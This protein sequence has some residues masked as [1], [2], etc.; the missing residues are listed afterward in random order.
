MNFKQLRIITTSL[1]LFQNFLFP[2]TAFA[3]EASSDTEVVE[4]TTTQ[5]EAPVNQEETTPAQVNEVA[6]TKETTEAVATPEQPQTEQPT[7]VSEETP[8]TAEEVPVVQG[9]PAL[10]AQ[11]TNEA[12]SEMPADTSQTQSAPIID[13]PPLLRQARAA[14]FNLP[15]LD[16]LEPTLRAYG[17]SS[18]I[19][20]VLQKAINNQQVT[21]G[22]AV[23]SYQTLSIPFS[24]YSSVTQDEDRGW[25]SQIASNTTQP[26]Y[27][28]QK[29]FYGNAPSYPNTFELTDLV[30]SGVPSY[31]DVTA[32]ISIPST[33]NT[34]VLNVTIT[35][36]QTTTEAE[37]S[38]SISGNLKLGT[39]AIAVGASS[40]FPKDIKILEYT[41][42]TLGTIK[43]KNEAPTHAIKSDVTVEAQRDKVLPTA[44][45]KSWFSTLPSNAD[46]YTYQ[47][48][49][50]P[51]TWEPGTSGKA[52]VTVSSGGTSMDYST[53]YKVEDTLPPTGTAQQGNFEA[54]RSRDF[55]QEE[56]RTLV[57]DL[58]DNWT[59]SKN[60][61]FK[62]DNKLSD[63]PPND[64]L[65]YIALSVMDEAGNTLKLSPRAY[66]KDT[67]PPEGKLKDSLV[68]DLGS[69]EPNL[70]ELL[71]GDPSDNWTLPEDIKL[72]ITFENGKKFSELPVGEHAFT[73]TLTD[74]SNNSTELKG[75]LTIRSSFAIQSDVIV[76]AQRDKDLSRDILKSWFTTLPEDADD[77]DY[78]VTSGPEL[79][80]PKDTGEATVTVKNK[81]TNSSQQFTTNY[82]V[83]DTLAP[84]GKLKDSLEF[85]EGS[86]EPDLHELLDG[87]PTDNWTLPEDIKLAI[88]FENGK[89]FSELPVGEHNFTLTLTDESNNSTELK[90]KLTIRSS[91]AIQSDVI[92]EAQRD[93]ELSLGILKSWFTTLPEKTDDYDYQVV[94]GPETWA[95]KDTGKVTV[96]VRNKNTNNTQQFTTNYTV[97]DTL[98]PNGKLKDALEFEEGSAEPD[99][100]KLLD[101]DPTDNWSFPDD[102]KLA[103]T[104]ENGKKF[105]EL[106][107]GEHAFTLTLT[108]ES[109]NS[110]ELKGS[111]HIFSKNKYIDVVIP[112]KM[113]FAQDKSSDGIVSPIYK[114]QNNSERAL[115]VSVD[116][117][118]SIEQT[119]RL[120]ELTLG[121][122]NTQQNQEILLVSN[123]QNLSNSVELGTLSPEKS[124]YQFSFF[125]SAG[126]NIDLEALLVPIKPVYT[127]KLHFK[128]Q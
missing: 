55:T 61:T 120:P 22:A 48:T 63:Y 106:P 32:N 122:K 43:V 80:A 47:V 41:N 86:A 72:A 79:W 29:M 6:E 91:F 115:T 58:N 111:L 87:D 49:S 113:N 124:V 27:Y 5:E 77:Y 118:T 2:I 17:Q 65:R 38:F 126:P 18:Y 121:M 45:I 92:V 116:S 30:R 108:D 12:I 105:S 68:Y 54:N 7:S 94:T 46:S 33:S 101:G 110:T 10:E 75:K 67:L 26:E 109:N 95:P 73:L 84:N 114:I 21:L 20:G 13:V 127:M 107:V 100:R 69:A 125:G 103:I 82:S 70:R 56:L 119:E 14:L 1:L 52:T 128:V 71:D 78:E 53:N 83:R 89:K 76:E 57:S 64:E 42:T 123:G 4:S 88:T 37:S 28:Y 34:R 90:G 112:A 40:D 11:T 60:I 44:T 93:K 23:G 15:N 19:E 97:R 96:S 9:P 85:D 99:L 74:E 16:K 81:N 66:I 102:I 39:T 35:R 98:A 36:K 3:V 31:L 8:P 104:F 59:E 50:G 51:S 25:I 117:M 24:T 62:T